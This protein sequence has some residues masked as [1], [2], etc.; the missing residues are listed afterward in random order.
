MRTHAKVQLAHSTSDAGAWNCD[1]MLR[2]LQGQISKTTSTVG[3]IYHSNC[4]RHQPIVDQNLSMCTS[5]LPMSA[6]VE[7]TLTT[8][9]CYRWFLKLSSNCLLLK[10]FRVYPQTATNFMK[11][12]PM[13]VLRCR[14]LTNYGEAIRLHCVR[15][16]LHMLTV[17]LMRYQSPKFSS[18]HKLSSY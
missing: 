11:K 8:G 4:Q 17:R 5:V 10:V 1:C 7:I 18:I 13:V 9:V 15:W 16:Q 2:S 3:V 12:R 14:C 6:Q